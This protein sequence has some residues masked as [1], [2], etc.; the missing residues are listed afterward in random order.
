MLCFCINEICYTCNELVCLFQGPV[1]SFSQTLEDESTTDET[2]VDLSVTCPEARITIRSALPSIRL[3]SHLLL[4]NTV[5]KCLFNS[6]KQILLCCKVILVLFHEFGIYCVIIC[7]LTIEIC[8]CMPF[9]LTKVL[10]NFTQIALFFDRFP[11]PDLRNGS[12]VS[13]LPWWQKNL[14]DELLVLDMQE[15]RFQTSFL[16]NQ[17]LQQLELSSRNILGKHVKTTKYSRSSQSCKLPFS[18][19]Y[20][21]FFPNR[22]MAFQFLLSMFSGYFMLFN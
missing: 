12:E 21:F 18:T 6:T 19:L 22:H 11:I 14:R 10:P 9:M 15:A 7:I 3:F 17:P 13:K 2:K 20:G 5:P 8:T 4:I 1:Y 16:S